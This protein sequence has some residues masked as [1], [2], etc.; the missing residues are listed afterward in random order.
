MM[1]LFVFAMGLMLSL[2]AKA[3]SYTFKELCE[4]KA[5]QI[6]HQSFE[7]DGWI[8]TQNVSKI[9]ARKELK[10]GATQVE[11]EM[12]AY[13]DVVMDSDGN[14][15]RGEKTSIYE[16]IYTVQGEFC[17]IGTPKLIEDNEIIW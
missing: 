6:A 14:P 13:M 15:I 2:G 17:Y 16:V 8:E 7:E 12:K 10:N 4:S 9:L 11:F 5:E 1:K 3:N